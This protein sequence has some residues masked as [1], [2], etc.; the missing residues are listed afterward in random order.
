MATELTLRRKDRQPLGS[1]EEVQ[2][3]L[4]RIFPGV[5]FWRT[6]SGPEKVELAEKNGGPLP[7]HIKEWMLTLPSM[8]DGVCEGDGWLVEFGLGPTEP[9]PELYVQPRGTNDEELFRLLDKLEAEYGNTLI[10]SGS[11]PDPA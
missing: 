11:E 10:V 3:M 1:F 8:L 9:V 5:Q 7:P 6:T 2:A 4:R